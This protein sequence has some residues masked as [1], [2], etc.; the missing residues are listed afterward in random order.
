MNG[1]DSISTRLFIQ[2]VKGVGVYPIKSRDYIPHG[3]DAPFKWDIS[4]NDYPIS[5]IEV[6][7]FTYDDKPITKLEQAVKYK[8]NRKRM[9]E[10]RK[11]V[12]P[13]YKYIDSMDKLLPTHEISD[14]SVWAS[15]Y[16]N[17]DNIIANIGNEEEWWDMFEVMSW[18]TQGRGWDHQTGKSIYWRNVKAMKKMVDDALKA[19][20]P[21]V[22][23]VVI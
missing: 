14:R 17:G 8:V 20:N 5:S 2:T 23:D 9:N 18:H 21:Q 3:F 16:R 1:Y 15:K 6:Y 22:L 11:V 10:V 19:S 7:D 13:F 12:V 4:Y